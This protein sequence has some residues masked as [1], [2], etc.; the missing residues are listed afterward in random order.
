MRDVSYILI[1]IE[2]T[3]IA[4]RCIINGVIIGRTAKLFPDRSRGRG[5]ALTPCN[6]FIYSARKLFDAVRH[7]IITR[8]PIYW[9]KR[10]KTGRVSNERHSKQVR[11]CWRVMIRKRSS[12][13]Q[14]RRVTTLRARANRSWSII[15]LDRQPLPDL[16]FA[17]WAL[18][19]VPSD[20]TRKET[21]PTRPA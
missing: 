8:F 14:L 9:I 7:H 11:F 13:S 4:A 6:R 17:T 5:S 19:Y 15:T 10:R 16:L 12:W 2:R 3:D 1:I 21:K 20:D 18:F